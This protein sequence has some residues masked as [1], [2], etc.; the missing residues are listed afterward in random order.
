MTLKDRK[1]QK[2]R[3]AMIGAGLHSTL[4]SCRASHIS[5]K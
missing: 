2:G 3:K 4:A 5:A 1:G